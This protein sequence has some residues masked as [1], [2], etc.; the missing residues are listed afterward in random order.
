MH[1]NSSVQK[2]KAILLDLGASV[3][4]RPGCG[5]SFLGGCVFAEVGEL[6]KC[7]VNGIVSFVVGTGSRVQR[8]EVRI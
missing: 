8:T 4:P 7:G 5:I 3:L 1:T 2:Q 6:R